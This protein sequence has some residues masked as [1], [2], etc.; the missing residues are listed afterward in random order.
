MFLAG[1]NPYPEREIRFILPAR[2][3]SRIINKKNMY[4]VGLFP[5]KCCETKITLANHK[6]QG[7]HYSEPISKLKVFI[8]SWHNAQGHLC[9]QVKIGFGFTLLYFWLDEK[10]AW[11]F[12][13]PII[14]VYCSLVMQNQ[15]HCTLGHSNENCFKS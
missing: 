6:G 3:A 13:T 9:Q 2:G 14:I 15:L 11:V 1:H 5:I 8:C 7:L 10:M 4:S 12:F